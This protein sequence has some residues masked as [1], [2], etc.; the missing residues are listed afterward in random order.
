M[1][2]TDIVPVF[3]QTFYYIFPI[4]LLILITINAFDVYALIAKMF[5]LQ[6]FIFESEFSHDNIEEGRK[7]LQKARLDIESRILNSNTKDLR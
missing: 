7:L 2:E 3:G 6:K 5:G 4:L 1:G